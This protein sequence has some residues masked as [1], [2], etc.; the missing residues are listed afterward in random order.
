MVVRLIAGDEHDPRHIEA[1]REN[2][3]DHETWRNM[4]EHFPHPYTRA[5]AEAWLEKCSSEE[6]RLHF[7]IEADGEIVG[8]CGVAPKTGVHRFSASVG[9]YIGRKY[10]GR[11]YATAA[12]N[13][14][15]TYAFEV[16]RLVRLE[17]GVYG[18]NPASMR[19]LEKAGFK[20]EAVQERA[21]F[22]DGQFTDY[23]T[24]VR[25]A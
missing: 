21:V 20:R 13:L 15:A 23:V 12:V 3:D 4:G 25:M 8:G 22:K 14:I 18:W 19:V 24:F 11:G 16:L 17:A 5:H 9:Y 7:L 2:S 10:Q 6:P 1:D